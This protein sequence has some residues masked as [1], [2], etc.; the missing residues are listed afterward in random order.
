MSVYQIHHEQYIQSS[1]ADVWDFI[2]SPANLKIITPEYMGFDITSSN[3]PKKIYQGMIISYKVKPLWGIRMNWVTEIT[4]VR[5]GKFFVDEQKAGPYS[6][7]HH[8]HHLEETHKGVRMTDIVTYKPPLWFLGN[9]ANT[10]FIKKQLDS[11]FRFR[12]EAVNKI[13]RNQVL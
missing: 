6:M 13:F 1:I 10:V 8:Q 4:H 5:E 9:M 12:S 3:L 2:S 11:I 7:W